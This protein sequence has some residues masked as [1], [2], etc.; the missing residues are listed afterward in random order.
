VHNI[1]AMVAPSFSGSEARVI[2][3]RDAQLLGTFDVANATG[4]PNPEL[5]HVVNTEIDAAGNVTGLQ[6]IQQ[7]TPGDS[8]FVL[9][10]PY[11]GKTPRR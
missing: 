5:W 1:N 2:V 4:D 11:G 3:N 8:V 9:S 7:C 10:P 6:A